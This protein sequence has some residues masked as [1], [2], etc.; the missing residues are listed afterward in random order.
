MSIPVYHRKKAYDS[1]SEPG[2]LLGGL[3]DGSASPVVISGGLDAVGVSEVS[4][5]SVLWDKLV[6]VMGEDLGVVV[7]VA[8]NVA[9]TSVVGLSVIVS[10]V[11]WDDE[12]RK[13]VED[14]GKVDRDGDDEVDASSSVLLFCSQFVLFPNSSS[15][16]GIPSEEMSSDFVRNQQK[17]SKA[18]RSW[19]WYSLFSPTCVCFRLLYPQ[20]LYL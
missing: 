5:I 20:T 12:V 14:G 6:A 16:T 13:C 11:S 9:A 1:W 18:Y 2:C 19:Y 4:G 8:S 15:M 7:I 17:L 10:S 3:E